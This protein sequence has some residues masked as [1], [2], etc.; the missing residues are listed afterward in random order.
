[1]PPSRRCLVISRHPPL[2]FPSPRFFPFPAPSQP[3][4][5]IISAN[6]HQTPPSYFFAGGARTP[7]VALAPAAG[8]S[9]AHNKARCRC[10]AGRALA[11]SR[12][13]LRRIRAAAAWR[14]ALASGGGGGGVSCREDRGG[15]G[16]GARGV[17]LPTALGRSSCVGERASV[18]PPPPPPR[19]PS[20]LR[21]LPPPPL[22]H[23]HPPPRRRPR[24][25]RPRRLCFRH[26]R[27][28]SPRAPPPTRLIRSVVQFA[29]GLNPG[30][31]SFAQ[32][33]RT[34]RGRAQPFA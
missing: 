2:P 23:L 10:G 28:H 32:G 3:K 20:R 12:C 22:A 33:G 5:P 29:S 30:G 13:S 17:R 18:P 15:L 11:S 24:R 26:C 7:A 21:P 14:G 16:G 27:D 19:H 8:G 31:G 9:L 4:A 34:C 25:H 1:M 6:Y